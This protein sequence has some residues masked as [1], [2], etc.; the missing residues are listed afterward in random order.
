MVGIFHLGLGQG[1]IAGGAPVDG[2]AAATDQPIEK[3][4]L[5]SRAMAAS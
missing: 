4:L 2:L 3:K 5:N 1:G